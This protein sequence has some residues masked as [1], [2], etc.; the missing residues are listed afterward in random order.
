MKV[1]FQRKVVFQ[2]LC[3]PCST[4]ELKHGQG[5]GQGGRPPTEFD[6]LPAQRQLLDVLLV[7]REERHALRNASETTPGGCVTSRV[8][9]FR[10]LRRL[11]RCLRKAGQ[12]VGQR[13]GQGVIF[14]QIGT[15]LRT[16]ASQT[17]PPDRT[18][19][20]VRG[21]RSHPGEGS[22][23]RAVNGALVAG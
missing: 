16:D 4:P 14:G 9:I 2:K 8:S 18:Q 5:G 10:H 12:M 23:E 1:V 6:S 15:D 13:K 3:Q 11:L 7:I 17:R 22:N 20:R 21:T 19:L